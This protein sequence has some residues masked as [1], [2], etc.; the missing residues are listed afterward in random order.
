[1]I[2]DNNGDFHFGGQHAIYVFGVN[3]HGYADN[4]KNCPFYDGKNNWVYDKLSKDNVSD[5][6]SV[7]QSLLWVANPIAISNAFNIETECT[8]SVRV[9][10]EY[11]DFTATG[12]NNGRP[13]YGWEI[14]NNELP[15]YKITNS[16][17]ICNGGFYQINGKKYYK[18]G[19]YED[20]FKSK[21]GFDSII[22]TILNVNEPIIFKEDKQICQGQSYKG[23]SSSG[24]YTKKLT[25]S[26]GCDSTLIL[27]LTVK[28]LPK[29]SLSFKET[30]CSNKGSFQLDSLKVGLPKGGV[31]TGP[32]VQKDNIFDPKGLSGTV[33][34]TYTFTDDF[35]CSSSVTNS[36]KISES[37]GASNCKVGK[38]E[39]KLS[40]ILSI[41]PNPTNDFVSIKVSTEISLMNYTLT[42]TDIVGKQ[43]QVSK[44]NATQTDISLR[45]LGGVGVYMVNLYDI[46]GRFINSHRVVLD[47]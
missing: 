42:I 9:N 44:I 24:I 37:N 19:V 36:V 35:G 31:F 3:V 28:P 4:S 47:D 43:L 1:V 30:L 16:Q 41:Y 13:M 11:N 8:I 39:E 45:N 17:K 12:L 27:T 25:S 46:N 38:V 21:N 18:S 2:Q 10:K 5:Y 29:V 6:L 32:L 15:V 7:Y 26:T 33:A 14:N 22:T 34:L 40:T 20:V 23:Y